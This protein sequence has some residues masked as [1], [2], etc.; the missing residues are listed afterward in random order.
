MRKRSILVLEDSDEDFATVQD[1]ARLAGLP[2]PIV[3]AIAGGECLRL[4][5]S[6]LQTRASAPLLVLLDLNTPGDDGREALRA[7]RQDAAFKA[8]PLVVLSASA[9]PRDLQFCYAAGANAYH[10]KPVE[11]ALHLQLLR[12]IFAYWLGCVTLPA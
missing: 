11:H 5:R 1:A 10:V 9:N 6:E 3:R 7:I 8:L 2:H 4:L 12:Q